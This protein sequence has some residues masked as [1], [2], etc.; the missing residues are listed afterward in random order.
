MI[1]GDGST[2]VHGNKKEQQ[3]LADSDYNA[4]SYVI[5]LSG[6]I[7]KGPSV[8]GRIIRNVYFRKGKRVMIHRHLTCHM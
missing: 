1:D 5:T 2:K 4:F 6:R 8:E 3:A 7:D